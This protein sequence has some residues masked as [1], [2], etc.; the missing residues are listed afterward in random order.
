MNKLPI[1]HRGYC[2][3]CGCRTEFLKGRCLVCDTK[4]SKN[5]EE[6]KYRKR[7]GNAAGRS[8]VVLAIQSP[9]SQKV[10]NRLETE[11]A[12]SVNAERITNP[13]NHR[14]MWCGKI[15]T[16]GFVGENPAS[17]TP[18]IKPRRCTTRI[19]RTQ[20]TSCAG[21]DAGP[22]FA[23]GMGNLEMGET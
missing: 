9:Q 23:Q 19:Q 16:T 14:K 20:R 4:Q 6:I 18:Q 3:H 13:R 1:L 8:S 21:E 22:L 2:F 11:R 17:I 15:T 10:L 7:R 12:D 5:G